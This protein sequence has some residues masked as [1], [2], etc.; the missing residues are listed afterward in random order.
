[1]MIPQI[2]TIH[3]DSESLFLRLI[4]WRQLESSNHCFKNIWRRR[5]WTRNYPSVDIAQGAKA[6][7]RV[8]TVFPKTSASTIDVMEIAAR[9]HGTRSRDIICLG[10]GEQPQIVATVDVDPAHHCMCKVTSRRQHALQMP[11]NLLEYL[12]EVQA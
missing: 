1:M 5:R 8:A 11:L 4:P 6:L 9:M 12:V 2:F 7:V 3:L 10:Y